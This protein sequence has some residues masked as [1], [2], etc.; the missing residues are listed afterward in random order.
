MNKSL[1]MKPPLKLEVFMAGDVLLR[2][3]GF[4]NEEKYMGR[5]RESVRWLS[6]P[7]GLLNSTV[8]NNV[9][10]FLS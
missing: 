1:F 10:V 5:Y 3:N 6:G 2:E 8:V 4:L 9:R 7:T